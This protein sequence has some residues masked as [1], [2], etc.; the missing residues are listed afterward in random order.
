M[1]Q[2]IRG[3][4]PE[5]GIMSWVVKH[6]WKL[7]FSVYPD[8]CGVQCQLRCKKRL[9]ALLSTGRGVRTGPSGKDGGTAPCGRH[10]LLWFAPASV[11]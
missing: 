7:L 3:K 9:S 2:R 1:G 10:S 11:S 6:E 4:I 5:E 8:A